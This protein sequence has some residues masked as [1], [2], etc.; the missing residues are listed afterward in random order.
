[1][2]YARRGRLV[3]ASRA[4]TRRAG[5]SVGGVLGLAATPDLLQD[6][7]KRREQPTERE[8]AAARLRA[9]AAERRSAEHPLLTVAEAARMLRVSEMTIR[10]A[11]DAGGLPAIRLGRTRRIPRAYVQHLLDQATEGASTAVVTAATDVD[12]DG[13]ERDGPDP[14]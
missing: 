12:A 8:T 1:M 4:D 13:T 6:R 14:L 2:A 10:R 11:C 5:T 7:I 3:I 9:R